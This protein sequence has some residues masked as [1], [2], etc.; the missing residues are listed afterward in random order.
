[1]SGSDIPS[2]LYDHKGY[3]GL[4]CS[5]RIRFSQEKEDAHG[6]SCKYNSIIPT[7]CEGGWFAYNVTGSINIYGEGKGR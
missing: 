1:M 2:S 5:P 3:K 7:L 4:A 6:G